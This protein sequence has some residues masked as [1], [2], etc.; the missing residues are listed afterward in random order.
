MAGYQAELDVQFQKLGQDM[1]KTLQAQYLNVIWDQREAL[2]GGRHLP[3]VSANKTSLISGRSV[4]SGATYAVKQIQFD[5]SRCVRPFAPLD[6]SAGLCE[7]AQDININ[8]DIFGRIRQ[9]NASTTSEILWIQGPFQAPIPS[10]YTL[11]SAYMVATAQ[12]AGIPAISYFC[13]QSS[14]ITDVT[15][16]IIEQLVQILPEHFHSQFDFT[17]ARFDSL[18]GTTATLGHAVELLQDLLAVGPCPLY[19]IIDG[20]QILDT[21]SNRS[22]L[23]MLVGALNPVSHKA[24]TRDL[25][26]IKVLITTDGFADVLTSLEGDE[27][28]DAMDF[29]GEEGQGAEADGMEVSF[30]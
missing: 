16:S 12:R 7:P 15:Y 14:D 22:G 26:I 27:R 11:M 25:Q 3:D 29:E 2:T 24:G 21:A 30:L 20:L 9:W 17:S 13:Q 4:D 6:H 1:V 19:I 18:D 28:L 23:S 5:S 8:V 10:R